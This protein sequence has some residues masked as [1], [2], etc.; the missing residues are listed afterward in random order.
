MRA[1]PED[2]RTPYK[3]ERAHSQQRRRGPDLTAAQKA[4][5][6]A[7]AVQ[8]PSDARG[9]VGT[10]ALCAETGVCPDYLSRCL[11]PSV[12][13]LADDDVPFERKEQ[14]NKGVP[15]KLTPRKDEAMKEKALEWG[16]GSGGARPCVAQSASTSKLW[17]RM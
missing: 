14:T 12:E 2:G 4:K 7:K 5:M 15:V 17:S 16:C 1:E 13:A 8:L 6:L 10:G 3:Q 11:L 9:K